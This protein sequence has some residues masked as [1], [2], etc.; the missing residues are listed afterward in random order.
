MHDPEIEKN[1]RLRPERNDLCTGCHVEMG[2]KTAGHTH[3]AETSAGSSCVEC[4]MPRTVFSIKAA[5]RDH[6]ISPPAPE[7]TIRHGIPNACNVCH[8][9]RSAKWALEWV[10]RWYPGRRREKLVRRADAFA[11]ARAGNPESLSP[12]L[13]ILDDPSEGPLARANAAGH[14]GRRFASNPRAVEALVEAVGA[15]HPL[16]RAVAALN[17]SQAR[18]SRDLVVPALL[19]SLF[20]SSRTVRMSATLSLLNFGVTR[21]GGE[22]GRSFESAKREYLIRAEIN[23]DDALSQA[24]VGKFHLLNGDA[25]PAAKAF[26]TSLRLDPDRPAVKYYLALTQVAQNRQSEAKELLAEIPERDPLYNQA[27]ALLKKLDLDPR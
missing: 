19:R 23:A 10:E 21:L 1:A 13:A 26:E 5:I 9:D 16:V 25:A 15:D 20:D 24:E 3:H 4:H 27:R 14:L 18:E 12:L 17:L 11:G 22:A 8:Q 6:S 2:Q 7:N